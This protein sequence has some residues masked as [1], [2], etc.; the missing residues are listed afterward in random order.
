MQKA[1]NFYKKA[2]TRKEWEQPSQHQKDVLA[3]QAQ[4]HKLEKKA[5]KSLSF[6]PDAK[7]HD[8][9]KGKSDKKASNTASKG[10]EKPEWLKKDIRPKDE[11]LTKY[12]TWNNGKWFWCSHETGGKCPGKWRIHKPSDCK[13]IASKA[14]K[15]KPKAKKG[16]LKRKA[17][18]LKIAAANEALS[19]K[20]AK[21]TEDEEDS[22]YE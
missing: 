13:G 22:D 17:D 2:V 3:L 6:T 14:D 4:V 11:S 15:E 16:I 20:V 8:G 7:K 9:K 12:R 5:G 21:E 19:N 18:A 1:C 10:A